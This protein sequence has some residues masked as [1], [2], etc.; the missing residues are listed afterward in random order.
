M[1]S[2][3]SYQEKRNLEETPEPDSSSSESASGNKPTFVI[4]KH[5]ASSLHYDFRLEING[6]LK[7]WAVPK[8]PS[9]DPSEKRLAIPTEDHPLEYGSFEGVIPEDQ[10]GGGTVM[11]WDTGSYEN[12]KTEDGETVSAGECYENG[13]IEVALHGE[14]IDG[15][16]VLVR[17]GGNNSDDN[18][19]LIKMDDGQADAR[20]NP[21]GT[22]N[23]S[24][25][26]GRTMEQIAKEGQ[27]E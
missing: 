17:T 2:Q 23:K 18:W 5:D 16:Y 19:L 27:D 25:K 1:S 14:K 20:R 7:S 15:G 24:V 9:T 22:E 3:T 8:G 6:S 11:M 13:Q 12:I 10:Y 26:S 21:T 4:Q